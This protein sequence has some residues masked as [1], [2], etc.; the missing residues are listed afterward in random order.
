MVQGDET[1]WRI[2]GQPAWAWC[3]RDPRLALFLI[4]RHRSGD[5]LIRV[6][7]ES[8]AGT[9]VSDFYA[10]YNGLDCAK[11][12]CLVHLLRELAKLRE[13]LPW[14]SVRAFIQPS[15]DLFQDAIQLGKDR[16][17]GAAKRSGKPPGGS[18]VASTI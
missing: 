7:G 6:L 17:S 8:F 4:D 2:D 14:Q 11:Q 16:E 1:G 5:V 10:A 12:R 18:S 13:E 9:L 15:I 3:F